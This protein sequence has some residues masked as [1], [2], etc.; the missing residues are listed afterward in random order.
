[1]TASIVLETEPTRPEVRPL[2]ISVA[3]RP[4]ESLIGLVAR[5]TRLNVL[6]TTKVI[7]EDIGLRLLHP[8][9]LGQD[10]GLAAPRLAQKL[11]CSPA[12]INER[13]HPYLSDPQ[14]RKD[15]R[16]GQGAIFRPDISVKR[17]RVSPVALEASPYHRSSWMNKL[18]PY[19][20][21]TFELLVDRCATCGKQQGWR[22]AWG[23]GNCDE[24]SCRALLVQ[25]TGEQLPDDLKDDYRAFA[26]IASADHRERHEAISKLSSELQ[27]LPPAVLLNLTLQLGATF[28]HDPMRF[29]RDKFRNSAP[30]TIATVVARGAH[31]LGEWPARVRS[32][33]AEQVALLSGTEKPR[34]RPYLAA[35]RQLGLRHTVR[36]EQMK[37]VRDALPEAFEH[38]TVAL[39]ALVKPAMNASQLCKMAA[40]DAEELRAIQV[41]NLIEH[42]VVHSGKRI[43]VQY[44]LESG[45]DF[46]NRM[47][48]SAFA[49]RMEQKLGIP[50][51]G[52]EQLAC[53]GEIAHEDHPGAL[54]LHKTMRLKQATVDELIADLEHRALRTPPPAAAIKLRTAMKRIGGREKPWG[55]VLAAM[56]AGEMPFWLADGWKLV[57]TAY[58]LLE[59]IEQFLN[60]HFQPARWPNFPFSRAM[61]K[62]DASDVLNLDPPQIRRVVAAGE[63]EFH[64]DGVALMT[65]R[66]AVVELASRTIS[67]AEIGLRLGIPIHVVPR[68]LAEHPRIK[69]SPAGWIRAD[70]EAAMPLHLHVPRFDG[71]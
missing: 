37:V 67:T 30:E 23:I 60:V 9:T 4:G 50:R 64:P 47:R 69:R 22:H 62:I 61:T 5:A 11:G 15:V 18:L 7:L 45:T 53:L 36:P 29:Q 71:A 1:M 66:Q 46:A 17:R 24:Y 58:V 14:G 19:C 59:D 39:A 42:Q 52:S 13:C 54:L 68:R 27:D 41:A 10:I 43:I 25:P 70:F 3:P 8:G 26:A 51:Y 31:L 65:S 20:P 34:L 16:W 12:E 35:V 33:I 40:I 2:A 38:A 57:G 28:G 49:S 56:R 32:D 55:H 44:D 6:G 21:E 48:S 63:L